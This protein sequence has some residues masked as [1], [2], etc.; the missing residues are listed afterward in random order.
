V[1]RKRRAP[2]AR[3]LLPALPPL[4]VLGEDFSL[5]VRIRRVRERRDTGRPDLLH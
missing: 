5:L 4:A 1:N 2:A 3:R